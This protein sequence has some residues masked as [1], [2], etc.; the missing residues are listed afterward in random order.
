MTQKIKAVEGYALV[1]EHSVIEFI[2]G[3]NSRTVASRALE[4]YCVD[5]FSDLR[6]RGF[7]IIKVRIVPEKQK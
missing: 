1:N 6:E 7:R 3:W 5:D 2:T 4:R